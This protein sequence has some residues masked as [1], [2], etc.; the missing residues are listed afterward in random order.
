MIRI[1]CPWCGPRD[2]SEFVYVGDATKRRPDDGADGGAWFD[3]VYVRDNPRGP[4]L[5]YW[6][7]AQ[8]CGAFVKVLRDTAT[9]E[10]LAAGRPED[11]LAPAGGAEAGR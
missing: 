2:H 9:H 6:R 5:E 11:D 1:P 4:H 3:F 10:V 8:G 7:H